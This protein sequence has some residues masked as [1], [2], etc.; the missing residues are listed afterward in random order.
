MSLNILENANE[1]FATSPAFNTIFN[2]KTGFTATWGKTFEDDPPY[3]PYGPT[4][5][6]IEVSEVISKEEADNLKSRFHIVTKG[7][8]NGVGCREFCYKNNGLHTYTKHLSLEGIRRILNRMATSIVIKFNDNSITEYYTDDVDYHT[9]CD[10]Q[11]GEMINDLYVVS[12]QRKYLLQQA[13][14]GI[15]SAD[16]HPQL[17]EI[18]QEFRNRGIIPN[19][20]VN[21]I[22]F[23]PSLAQKY[24]KNFSAIAVS[25]NS[26]NKDAAYNTI[27]M[28][29]GAG[30]T[31]VNI[32]YVVSNENLDNRDA[33]LLV[34]DI[35]TD[36]RLKNLNAVVFLAYKNTRPKQKSPYTTIKD[37]QKLSPLYEYCQKHKIKYGM[38]SCSGPIYLQSIKGRPE[39]VRLKEAVETCCVG[40]FSSY[41]NVDGIFYGCSFLESS[42]EDGWDTG[43]NVLECKSFNQEVWH[44]SK[45]EKYRQKVLRCTDKCPC[46]F[47]DPTPN[48]A[49]VEEALKDYRSG[50]ESSCRLF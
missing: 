43:I 45:L 48:S 7:G 31:Q 28:L 18:A 47:F 21:G 12:I 5:L 27:E 2:K 4:I 46:S 35:I 36:I 6:D 33:F 16:S 17:F 14:L 32:H 50:N 37:V 24:V 15:C 41:I 20:T 29:C 8:C 38:D 3:C 25:V 44:S 19:I 42:K 23:T 13:A 40:R 22:G 11:V 9:V 1:K 10:L 26:M 34:D 30:C 39:E 49:V